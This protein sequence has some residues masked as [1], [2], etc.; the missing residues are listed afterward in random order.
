MYLK[1]GFSFFN[2]PF[3]FL[4]QLSSPL[5]HICFSFLSFVVSWSSF[6]VLDTGSEF[7]L[8][9]E[10]LELQMWCVVLY[11]SINLT[12]FIYFLFTLS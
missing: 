1:K 7:L 10:V 3:S 11:L 9:Y 5:L 12:I 6:V 4:I 8:A 2:F